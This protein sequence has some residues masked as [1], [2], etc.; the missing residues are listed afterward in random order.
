M[1]KHRRERGHLTPWEQQD[2]DAALA[3]DHNEQPS[4]GEDD[5]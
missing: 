1:G 5:G 3:A 2:E 4:E